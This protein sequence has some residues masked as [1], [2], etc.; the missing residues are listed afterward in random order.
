VDPVDRLQHP[1]LREFYS[2]WDGKRAGRPMPRRADIKSLLPNLMIVDAVGEDEERRFR[3]RLVGSA[4]VE[5]FGVNYVGTF[6]GGM[7]SGAYRDLLLK[8]Y[9][10]AFDTARPVFSRSR[11]H[12]LEQAPKAVVRLLLPLSEDGRTAGQV[13]SLHL[14]DRDRRLA[15]PAPLG[16][17]GVDENIIDVL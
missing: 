10:T 12:R 8:I 16:E 13:I 1:R 9:G 4:L 7:T 15:A 11:Y 17:L 2:Y 3:Y 6:V 5:A 14:F